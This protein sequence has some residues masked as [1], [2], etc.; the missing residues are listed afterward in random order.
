MVRIAVLHGTLPQL[1][2]HSLT[3]CDAGLKLVRT[4]AD[5]GTFRAG[6]ATQQIDVLVVDL[7]LLGSQAVREIDRLRRYTR[8]RAM[9]VTY[10]FVEP[11][12]LREVQEREDLEVVREPLTPTRLRGLLA[13]VM[14]MP[15]LAPDAVEPPRRTMPAVNSVFDEL[16]ARVPQDRRYDDVQ[17]NRL[18]EEAIAADYEFTQHIA[19]LLIQLTG[20]EDYCRRRNAGR[21]SSRGLHAD[22]QRTVAH[23]RALF[24][25]ALHRLTLAT[26][27]ATEDPDGGEDRIP[28]NVH[29]ITARN[30]GEDTGKGRHSR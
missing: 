11:Q 1:L 26:G 27:L 24:E 28:A 30:V 9:V 20:F 23:T 25:E 10:S 7:G 4:A 2:A 3:T 6:L 29:D 22:L 19:E 15:Q 12:V 8:A 5:V 13:R 16:L 18:F 17:L 21:S 14:D